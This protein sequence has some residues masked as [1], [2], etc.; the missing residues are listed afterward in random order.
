MIIHNHRLI[1]KLVELTRNDMLYWKSISVRDKEN[2][3]KLSF[4]DF[5]N[6]EK[7]NLFTC[8]ID[9]IDFFIFKKDEQFKL[10]ARI[11]FEDYKLIADQMNTSVL[12]ELFNMVYDDVPTLDDALAA[13]LN[14]P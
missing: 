13:W 8:S 1:N 10:I 4:Y 14:K 6:I 5:G 9:N 7:N 12:E 3:Y 11:E 2:E